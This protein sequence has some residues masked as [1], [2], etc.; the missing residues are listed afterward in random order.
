MTAGWMKIFSAD[1]RLGFLSQADVLE[2]KIAGG[3]ASA[4][5]ASGT[6]WSSATASTRS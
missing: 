4:Q 1:P 3:G 6:G 5:L 2:G